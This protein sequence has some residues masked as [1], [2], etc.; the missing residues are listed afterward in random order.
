MLVLARAV[1]LM[2]IAPVAVLLIWAHFVRPS[3]SGL[4]YI[5]LVIAALAGLVGVATAPWR[6]EVRIR[7][8]LAYLIAAILLLPIA[9]LFAV[10]STG[11]CL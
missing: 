11:D 9:G 5:V 7:L 10:C 6:S 4:D 1:F 8:G 2:V 3:L